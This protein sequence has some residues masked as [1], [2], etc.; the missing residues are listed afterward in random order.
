MRICLLFSC[1]RS[2]IKRKFCLVRIDVKSLRSI[3]ACCIDLLTPNVPNVLTLACG[4]GCF[5]AE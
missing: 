1:F 2:E 3:E 4:D 5:E